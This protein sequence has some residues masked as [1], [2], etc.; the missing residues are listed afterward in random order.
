MV[1]VLFAVTVD[2]GRALHALCNEVQARID[3]AKDLPQT[4]TRCSRLLDQIDGMV[5]GLNQEDK[6]TRVILGN[7]QSCV[8]ELDLLLT[9]LLAMADGV[10]GKSSVCL[11]ITLASKG[12]D[13]KAAEKEL[14]DTED[15]LRK[16]V[17]SLV[18]ATQLHKF[19]TRTANKLKQADA[20]RFWDEH[21]GDQREVSVETLAEA[22][23][24]EV[25]ER[26]Y[27]GTCCAFP[28]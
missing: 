14:G 10:L 19:S 25:N 22:L 11:C 26:E 13:V 6:R 3:A 8:A 15:E 1:D 16:H 28:N 12:K 21:F 18:Q 4:A 9:R 23:R 27:K 7:I 5:D 20:R 17:E 2:L 24:F